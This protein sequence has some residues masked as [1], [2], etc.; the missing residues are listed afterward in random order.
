MRPIA[1]PQCHQPGRL[2]IRFGA[3]DARSERSENHS[4]TLDTTKAEGVL[5]IRG[6]NG[7]V[8]GSKGNKYWSVW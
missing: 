5:S 7:K 4:G 8:L 3:S 2:P 1:S 6:E